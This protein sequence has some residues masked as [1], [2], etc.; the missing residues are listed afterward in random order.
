[1]DLDGTYADWNGEVI[2]LHNAEFGTRLRRRDV[3]MWDFVGLTKFATMGDLLRWAV[4]R[5]AYLTCQSYPGATEALRWLSDDGHTIDFL[6]HRPTG[7]LADTMLWLNRR[8][9]GDCRLIFCKNKTLRIGDY[10]LW[11]DDSPEVA[12]R[13]AAAGEKLLLMDRLWNR[14]VPVA[15]T[16][17]RVF[18]WR[19]VPYLVTRMAE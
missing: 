9:F 3:S 11:A 5:R 14:E 16:T 10:D 17:T 19:A 18:S 13:L 8:G 15:D 2:R 12:V 7:A 4:E 1:M 6:T